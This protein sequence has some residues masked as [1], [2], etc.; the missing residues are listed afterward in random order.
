VT[1]VEGTAGYYL[2]R[3]LVARLTVQFNDR[4]GGRVERKTY[5]AGQLAYWF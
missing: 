4:E 2:Q 3:N 1:R 5:V